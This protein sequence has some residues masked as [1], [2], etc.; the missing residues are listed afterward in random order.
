MTGKIFTNDAN[1]TNSLPTI[2]QGNLI[3][4]IERMETS[5]PQR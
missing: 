2:E 5:T 3:I 4:L 1:P